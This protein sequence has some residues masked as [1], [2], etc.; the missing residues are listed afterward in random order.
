MSGSDPRG[1]W[2][3]GFAVC[4]LGSPPLA[5]SPPRPVGRR[6][7]S[8]C[9]A[10]KR[11]LRKVSEARK[12][13][14]GIEAAQLARVQGLRLGRG[15]VGWVGTEKLDQTGEGMVTVGDVRVTR[16]SP[17]PSLWKSESA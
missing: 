2:L 9:Q 16:S 12:R 10:E 8:S 15:V 14:F 5:P 4:R 13:E 6:A 1:D 11:A 7:S 3:V 17:D